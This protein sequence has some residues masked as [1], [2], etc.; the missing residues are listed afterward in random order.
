[1]RI[2]WKA[3]GQDLLRFVVLFVAIT[4]PLLVFMFVPFALWG[5]NP[6]VGAMVFMGLMFGGFLLLLYVEEK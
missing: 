2:N 1:M 6:G 5:W 3:L 4:V